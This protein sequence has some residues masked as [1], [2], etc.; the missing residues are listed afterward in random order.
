MSVQGIIF[1]DILGLG[2]IILILN[3]VRTKRLHIAYATIWFLAVIGLM[4]MVSIPP[5]LTLLPKIMGAIYPASALSLL[6]FVFIFLVL[7]FFSMQ[8]STLSARQTALI[9]ALALRE[10]LAQENEIG[11]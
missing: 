11:D 1:I 5:V 3:L 6:G 4:L 9:Q 7:I 10:L 8:L 2:L